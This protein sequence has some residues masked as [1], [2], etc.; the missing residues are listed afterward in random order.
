MSFTWEQGT[1]LNEKGVFYMWYTHPAPQALLV[2]VL[3]QRV[4]S[5]VRIDI[6]QRILGY[7]AAVAEWI[8]RRNLSATECKLR[9]R[10]FEP[11]SGY[12]PLRGG[13]P[14]LYRQLATDSKNIAVLGPIME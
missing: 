6:F 11:R 4:L 14:R 10:K 7:R 1:S 5:Y 3:I 12:E 8:R 9:G 2:I 13:I